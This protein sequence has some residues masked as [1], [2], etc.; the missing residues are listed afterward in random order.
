MYKAIVSPVIS[1][2]AVVWWQ[3]AEVKTAARALQRLQRTACLAVLGA[4]RTTPT[5]A[6][7]KTFKVT[8]PS[9][10]E[11]GERAEEIIESGAVN[12]FT[13]SSHVN[14]TSGAGYYCEE[15]QLRGSVALGT[16][17]SVF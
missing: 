14:G 1:Y 4:M 5:A 7:E 16:N 10:A 11:W 8:T 12:L 9:R 3:R 15:P 6:M 2:A 13:D 17:T